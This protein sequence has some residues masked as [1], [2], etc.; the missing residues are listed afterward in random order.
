MLPTPDVNESQTIKDTRTLRLEA[1][2]RMKLTSFRDKDRVHVRDMLDV[3]LIDE[4]WLERY[5]PELQARLQE[6][7]DTP[8][9]VVLTYRSRGL[10][11]L[12]ALFPSSVTA[13]EAGEDSFGIEWLGRLDDPYGAFAGEEGAVG[14]AIGR[15]F[16]H[17]DVAFEQSNG[18]VGGDLQLV[19][20]P[21]ADKAGDPQ[22]GFASIWFKKERRGGFVEW[23]EMGR[24]VAVGGMDVRSNIHM[25]AGLPG[26]LLVED[27]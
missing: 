16:G 10:L 22:V 27:R 12:G 19:L 13:G 21:M 3:G 4:T 9:R 8:R 2:V 15:H 6:L 23:F 18:R 11:P 24:T 20:A 25:V 5:P 17:L 26:G 14:L 7:I 1:L